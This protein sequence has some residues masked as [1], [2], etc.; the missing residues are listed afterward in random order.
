MCG[1]K[2]WVELR[3]GARVF[4]GKKDLISLALFQEVWN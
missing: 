4:L 1:V 3:Q 2:E